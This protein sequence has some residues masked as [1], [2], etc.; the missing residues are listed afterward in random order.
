MKENTF[1][2]CGKCNYIP[3]LL[4]IDPYNNIIKYK[5]FNHGVTEMKLNKY[6]LLL[7]ESNNNI[8]QY[9]KC[10]KHPGN[11]IICFN[12]EKQEYY[13]IEC[14]KLNDKE[15]DI[16]F[17]SKAHI[18]N[19]IDINEIEFIDINNNNKNNDINED[20]IIKFL[21]NKNELYNN[22]INNYQNLI[23]LNN[24]LINSY[25]N[26][27]FRNINIINIKHYINIIK[28]YDIYEEEYLK[29]K[30]SKDLIHSNNIINFNRK[31]CT[32]LSKYDNYINLVGKNISNEGFNYFNNILNEECNPKIEIIDFSEN[33]ISNINSLKNAKYYNLRELYLYSNKISDIEILSSINYNNLEILNLAYNNIIDI[34]P[35]NSGKFYNLQKLYLYYNYI[36]DLS[37]IENEM[38]KYLKRIDLSHNKI[39]NIISFK[40][41]KFMNLEKL[42]LGDNKI[43]DITVFKYIKFKKLIVLDLSNNKIEDISPI[44]N[45]FHNLKELFLY[46]NNINFYMIKNK[47][48]ILNFKT[49]I[50]KFSI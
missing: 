13:C 8:N 14:Y 27:S 9:L 49:K 38:F 16:R 26:E 20:D 34:S 40:G 4:N 37:F 31:Y 10:C 33:N 36:E 46:N 43:D 21:K 15:N 18:P 35:L 32:N 45:G 3:I 17:F 6:L 48:I 2:S 22:L 23:K 29:N 39:K 28:L 11:D 44:E 50:E 42:F 41:A 30:N 12:Y 24:I 19:E 5:C 25:K 1:Y 47:D 7:N